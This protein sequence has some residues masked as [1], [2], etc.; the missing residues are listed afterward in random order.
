[1]PGIALR[2]RNA[3]ASARS[4]VGNVAITASPIVFTTAPA[5]DAT[6]FM[7]E[8]KVRAHQVVRHKVADPL[9]ERWSS[10]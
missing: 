7:Q 9:V 1:M 8:T 10:P 5:T 2:M 4:G 6:I 3:A